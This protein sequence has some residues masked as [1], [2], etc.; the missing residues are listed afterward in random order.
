MNPKKLL[1]NRWT[2]L[3]L[4]IGLA[5]GGYAF[6][7]QANTPKPGER[8]LTTPVEQGAVAQTVSANGTLNPVK[9]V[10]DFPSLKEKTI[11]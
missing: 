11:I 6:Y 1:I 7:R 2:A 4:I 10:S 8:Y 5:G 3:L 9:L